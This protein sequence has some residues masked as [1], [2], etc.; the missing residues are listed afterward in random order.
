YHINYFNLGDIKLNKNFSLLITGQSFT[1]IGD[2]LY[3]VGIISTIFGLT[4]LRLQ[5]LLFHLPLRL[6]CLYLVF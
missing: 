3:I 4:D 5:L 2:V 1:S 6:Q